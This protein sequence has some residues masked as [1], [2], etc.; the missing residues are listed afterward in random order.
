MEGLS[1]LNKRTAKLFNNNALEP[2]PFSSQAFGTKLRSK[3]FIRTLPSDVAAFAEKI[4]DDKDKGLGLDEVV[5]I[6]PAFELES[7]SGNF[8]EDE[9]VGELLELD[10][11]KGDG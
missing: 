1:R 6:D 3:R 2:S 4:V 11:T 8:M 9:F 7:I 10:P 5:D